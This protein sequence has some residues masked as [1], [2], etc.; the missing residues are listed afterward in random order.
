MLIPRLSRQSCV[1]PTLTAAIALAAPLP[2]SA[3]VS[4]ALELITG[5]ATFLGVIADSVSLWKEFDDKP[6]DD[7][8]LWADDNSTPTIKFVATEYR[9]EMLVQQTN[10]IS[11]FEDDEPAQLKGIVK[12]PIHDKQGRVIGIG[13][14]WDFSVTFEADLGLTTTD[15]DA[16]GFVQH[17]FAPHI[18]QG[19]R[20]NGGA[21]LDFNLTVSKSCT[22]TFLCTWS[23]STLTRTDSDHGVHADGKH[24]DNMPTASLSA[25]CCSTSFGDVDNFTFK[26][27][28]M[29]PIPEPSTAVLLLG[30][31]G[32]LAYAVK[33]RR[34][35]THRDQ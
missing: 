15:L 14:L 2:S 24:E 7:N 20:P 13:D 29:H 5:G 16:T 3:Q 32:V 35:A 22:G 33:R 26:L 30:G 23:Q 10:D 4:G 34:S 21:L 1:L 12:G 27:E 9:C 25:V 8:P 31:F 18:D 28:A 19:E 11:E 17:V 6:N